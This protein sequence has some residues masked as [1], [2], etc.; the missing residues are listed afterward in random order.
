MA[1]A[2]SW[3]IS[4]CMFAKSADEAWYSA[5]LSSSDVVGVGSRKASASWSFCGKI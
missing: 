5:A 3:S 1:L 2:S 4:P